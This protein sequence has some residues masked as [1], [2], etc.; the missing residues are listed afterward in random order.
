MLGHSKYN[1]QLTV[2]REACGATGAILIVPDGSSGPGMA[3]QLTAD[4]L[5]SM[6]RVLRLA[7]DLIEKEI[8]DDLRSI[9]ERN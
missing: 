2:A 6:P 1:D 9:F 4:Q 7:A 8:Q 5:R 3:V